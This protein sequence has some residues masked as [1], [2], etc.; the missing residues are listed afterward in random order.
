MGDEQCY[1]MLFA[2]NSSVN[3]NRLITTCNKKLITALKPSDLVRSK[4]MVK[5]RNVSSDVFHPSD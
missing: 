2:S 3:I 1:T 4:C 5:G